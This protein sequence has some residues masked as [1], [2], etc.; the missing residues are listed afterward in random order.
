[1]PANAGMTNLFSTVI[2]NSRDAE[3]SR[4]ATGAAP[5]Y[6]LGFHLPHSG[7]SGYRE[8]D[9]SFKVIL[10]NRCYEWKTLLSG[11]DESAEPVRR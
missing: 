7:L 3:I 5:F 8:V 9:R 1:M 11:G 10:L 2:P 6:K 4:W